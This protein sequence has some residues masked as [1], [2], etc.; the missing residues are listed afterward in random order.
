MCSLHITCY[1]IVTLLLSYL[2]SIR[3]AE[4][5]VTFQLPHTSLNTQFND[6]VTLLYELLLILTGSH[7]VVRFVFYEYLLKHL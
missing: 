6:Q 2:I 7:L 5:S 3:V 1:Y 4:I